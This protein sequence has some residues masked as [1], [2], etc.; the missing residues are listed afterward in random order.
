MNISLNI[1]CTLPPLSSSGWCTPF[2][3]CSKSWRSLHRMDC[4]FTEAYNGTYFQC[5]VLEEQHHVSQDCSL[6]LSRYCTFT[7]RRSRRCRN[8]FHVCF[9]LSSAG[10]Q[11][12]PKLQVATGSLYFSYQHFIQ[13]IIITRLQ[14]TQHDMCTT[15]YSLFCT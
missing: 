14:S 12:Q 10:S 2:A 8:N 7:L 5:R 13:A 11:I 3:M 9:H 4:S 1:N 15:R 6:E